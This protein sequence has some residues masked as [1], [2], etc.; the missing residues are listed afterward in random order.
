MAGVMS[1]AW[2]SSMSSYLLTGRSL[3]LGVCWLRPTVGRGLGAGSHQ[4][5]SFSKGLLIFLG[6][7]EPSTPPPSHLAHSLLVDKDSEVQSSSELLAPKC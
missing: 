3:R 1:V 6:N 4:S 7:S 2:C 5:M